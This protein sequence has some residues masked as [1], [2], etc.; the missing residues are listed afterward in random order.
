MG[1]T[2]ITDSRV[3]NAVEVP[4]KV[5]LVGSYEKSDGETSKP[6]KLSGWLKSPK[7]VVWTSSANF[8]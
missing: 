8:N 4:P 3:G 5:P 2:S 6:W 7:C 1:L